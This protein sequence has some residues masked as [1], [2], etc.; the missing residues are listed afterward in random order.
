[1]HPSSSLLSIVDLTSSNITVTRKLSFKGYRIVC[2]S[3]LSKGKTFS[4]KFQ[5]DNKTQQ[6]IHYNILR[7]FVR[8]IKNY[9][10]SLEMQI[11]G[12][13]GGTYGSQL[14]DDSIGAW[15]L[16][17]GAYENENLPADMGALRSE[18][19]SRKP[20]KEYL[21]RIFLNHSRGKEMCVRE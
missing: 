19:K 21:R 15:H 4:I 5:F 11:M 2:L 14:L 12:I 7:S 16:G 1:M 17:F 8:S 13:G 9:Q 20:F 18:K 10:N 3:G 6:D